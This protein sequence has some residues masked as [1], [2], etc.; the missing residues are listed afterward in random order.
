MKQIEITYK[1]RRNIVAGSRSAAVAARFCHRYSPFI[2]FF[3]FSLHSACLLVVVS[4]WSRLSINYWHVWRAEHMCKCASNS[5]L[6]MSRTHFG[7]MIC[8][9]HIST[10]GCSFAICQASRPAGSHIFARYSVPI[11]L[12]IIIMNTLDVP[13]LTWCHI[14]VVH[15]AIQKKM[16]WTNG[17]ISSLHTFSHVVFLSLRRTMWSAFH[18]RDAP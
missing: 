10:T 7:C 16:S 3:R 4:A 9:I 11:I 1:T 17:Y 12:I 6:P 13:L 14:V 15:I 8:A 5:G 18:W 2:F